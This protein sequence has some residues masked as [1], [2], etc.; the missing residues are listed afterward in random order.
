MDFNEKQ[1]E[2]M[3]NKKQM[4]SQLCLSPNSAVKNDKDVSKTMANIKG[5]VA[6]WVSKILLWY[7]L[8]CLNIYFG[9]SFRLDELE[10]KHSQFKAHHL[11]QN[12]STVEG[13][14]M[15]LSFI[16]SRPNKQPLRGIELLKHL[17]ISY[18][19]ERYANDSLLQGKLRPL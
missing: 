11:L 5:T 18:S 3:E 1:I 17:K 10:A 14:L 6:Q 2:M 13:N 19:G 12:L 4:S 9:F 8:H 16:P 15:H 7:V